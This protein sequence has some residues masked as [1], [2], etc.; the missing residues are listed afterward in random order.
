[1]LTP[2]MGSCD[3]IHRT[4]ATHRKGKLEVPRSAFIPEGSEQEARKRVMVRSEHSAY[5]IILQRL[6][7]E[8]YRAIWLRCTHQGCKLNVGGGIYSCPC[9]GSSFS[10]NGQVLEGPAN[11]ALHTLKTETTDANIII[12]LP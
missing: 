3:P 6:E 1:M 7:E 8:N 4:Q 5:P 2:M 9:H 10:K 12:H 11:E